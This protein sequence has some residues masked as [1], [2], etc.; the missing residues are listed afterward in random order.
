MKI[1]KL[2]LFTATSVVVANMVGTGVFTSLGFQAAG[3]Q[4]GSSIML[5]WLLGGIMSLAGALC[6][7]E[8]GSAIPR[9]GGEYIYLSEMIHPA[10]GFAAGWVS[11][12]VGFAAPVAAACMAFGKYLH[13]LTPAIHETAAALSILLILTSVQSKSLKLGGKVQDYSTSLKILVMT[14]FIIA[15]LLIPERGNFKFDLSD[16][17]LKD[18]A[19]PDFATSFFFVTLAYSGWN[20][21]AYFASDMERPKSQLPKALLLG[22]ILVSL[23]YCGI[24]YVFMHSTSAP[25]MTGPNG[26]V[27]EIA[28]VSASNIFG[29]KLGLMM[30]GIIA[31]LL[32]STINAMILAGPRVTMA[33]GQDHRVFGLFAKISKSGVPV[34]AI[35]TQSVISALFILSATFSQVIVYISF[36]LNLFTFMT[37]LAGFI[38]RLRKR[39]PNDSFKAPL[40]PVPHL[41]FLGI[42]GWLL[43]FGFNANPNE[44]LWGLL[45]AISGILVWTLSTRSK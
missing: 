19:T 22:T 29:P 16:E 38:N 25:E 32:I 39:G 23:I 35:I 28:A 45:T 40:F 4:T 42:S 30:G 12:T 36:T 31:M 13:N 2:G 44:S 8:T 26:P 3:L 18:V 17:F 37:V 5:L 34:T 33:M 6:Y 41:L 14:I 1:H 20:A 7:A 9:S 43:I 24:N 10:L 27:V 15:G 11:V 21:A